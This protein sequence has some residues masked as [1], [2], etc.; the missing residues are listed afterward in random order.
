MTARVLYQYK[1]STEVHSGY[2]AYLTPEHRWLLDIPILDGD[3]DQEWV[4]FDKSIFHYIDLTLGDTMEELMSPYNPY[5][6]YVI[7]VDTHEENIMTTDQL[8]KDI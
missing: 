3:V 8:R 4:D 1:G 7:W 2:V 5:D 6:Y